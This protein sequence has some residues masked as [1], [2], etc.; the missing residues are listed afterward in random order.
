MPL[1]PVT[2]GNQHNTIANSAALP[3]VSRLCTSHLFAGRRLR[4]T[5]PPSPDIRA[6]TCATSKRA[7]R[8]APKPGNLSRQ[9]PRY[10]RTSQ[11]HQAQPL[12]KCI[13]RDGVG[14]RTPAEWAQGPPTLHQ[15]CPPGTSACSP[16]A[17]PSTRLKPA[18]LV[19]ARLCSMGSGFLEVALSW[20]P[21]PTASRGHVGSHPVWAS[22][23]ALGENSPL[24]K[25]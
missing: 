2:G 18:P 7:L 22:M 21:P 3:L 12:P 4:A 6:M 11:S 20:F 15:R 9:P 1:S 19:G 10:C 24:A 14:T 8:Q 13:N 17:E 5:Q 25:A 16:P 23:M